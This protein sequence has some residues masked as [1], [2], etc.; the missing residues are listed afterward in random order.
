LFTDTATAVLPAT[1]APINV[2]RCEQPLRTTMPLLLSGDA[3]AAAAVIVG[4]DRRILF[5]NRN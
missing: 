2:D 4:P 5:P 3:R 1:L